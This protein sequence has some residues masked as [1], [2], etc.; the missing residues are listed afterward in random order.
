MRIE[1]KK[2]THDTYTVHEVDLVVTIPAS[3]RSTT[4]RQ[5][6]PSVMN[7]SPS[8]KAGELHIAF[9]QTCRRSIV[10]EHAFDGHLPD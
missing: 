10:V 4:Q 9:M 1:C 5:T 7:S 8:L 6:S 3:G 2:T